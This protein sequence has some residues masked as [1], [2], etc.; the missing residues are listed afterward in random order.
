MGV[1]E[2]I[3]KILF[4]FGGCLERFQW[5]FVYGYA[6]GLYCFIVYMTYIIITS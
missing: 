3:S 6:F 2:M 1:E 4:F 5:W